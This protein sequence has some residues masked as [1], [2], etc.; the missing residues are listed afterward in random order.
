MFQRLPD[1]YFA[2]ARTSKFHDVTIPN[3]SLFIDRDGNIAYST[4]VTLNVACNLELANYPMDS[5]TCGIRMVSC[6]L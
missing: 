5:Q 3:F 1:L 2:N 6:K 4:R